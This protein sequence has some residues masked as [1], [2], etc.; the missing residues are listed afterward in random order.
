MMADLKTVVHVGVPN[1]FWVGVHEKTH[2]CIACKRAVYTIYPNPV[3]FD[4]AISV[5]PADAER[6]CSERR[7]ILLRLCM[8]ILEGQIPP[9]NIRV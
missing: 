8:G 2:D 4:C 9:L 6:L 5:K 3:C 1:P 7:T